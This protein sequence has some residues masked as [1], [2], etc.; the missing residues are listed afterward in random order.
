MD[1]LVYVASHGTSRLHHPVLSLNLLDLHCLR[2]VALG[3][4]NPVETPPH[5]VIGKHSEPSTNSFQ[6]RFEI[7]YMYCIYI[8]MC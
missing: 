6:S 4:V 7:I 1:A 2:L 8:Y 5:N 3:S